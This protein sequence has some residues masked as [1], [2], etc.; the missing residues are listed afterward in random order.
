MFIF[1]NIFFPS[2]I[3]AEKGLLV[4]EIIVLGLVEL[5]GLNL[6]LLL[7]LSF[8][9]FLEKLLFLSVYLLILKEIFSS[10]KYV[11]LFLNLLDKGRNFP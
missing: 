2:I 9:I 1:I 4:L 5:L 6:V 10:N 8:L 7:L 3:F 11:E